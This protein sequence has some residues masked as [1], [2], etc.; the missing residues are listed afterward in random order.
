MLHVWAACCLR[1]TH[2]QNFNEKYCWAL[3]VKENNVFTKWICSLHTQPLT[4][5]K[6]G[7]SHQPEVPP[8]GPSDS[9][10]GNYGNL[11]LKREDKQNRGCDQ[12]CEDVWRI[13]IIFMD[14]DMH[15]RWVAIGSTFLGDGMH[16]L[17]FTEV[18]LPRYLLLFL[19]CDNCG[20]QIYYEQSKDCW[21]SN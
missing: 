5:I 10:K 3:F 21:K 12:Q 9:D 13:S 18:Q 17:G 4:V 8:P 19:V 2:F 1:C 16:L 14:T 11:L 7:L 20:V 6:M 15:N